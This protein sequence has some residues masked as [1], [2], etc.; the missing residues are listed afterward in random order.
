MCRTTSYFH[1]VLNN[2]NWRSKY[3]TETEKQAAWRVTGFL[4]GPVIFIR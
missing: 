3:G 4:L 2:Y 1:Y